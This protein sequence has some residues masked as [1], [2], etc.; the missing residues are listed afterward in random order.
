VGLQ[1]FYG[2]ESH[3]LLWAGLGA[4]R[5]NITVSAVLNRLNYCVILVICTEFTNLAA[6]RI[7]QNGELR[8]GDPCFIGQ[9]DPFIEPSVESY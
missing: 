7:M 8:V 9:V 5:G 6:G 3:S 1:T 2:Q 4:S